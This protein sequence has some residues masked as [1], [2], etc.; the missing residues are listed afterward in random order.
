VSACA[1]VCVCVEGGEGVVRKEEWEMQYGRN[2]E[3][4]MDILSGAPFW[5]HCRAISHILQCVNMREGVRHAG[6]RL[7]SV[8]PG[9]KVQGKLHTADGYMQMLFDFPASTLPES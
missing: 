5:Q 1:C 7:P 9:V 4:T 3:G 2:V 6:T 8:L